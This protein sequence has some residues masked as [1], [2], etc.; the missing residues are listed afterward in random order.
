MATVC[1][2]RDAWR[3]ARHAC[4]VFARVSVCP[5]CCKG[6]F[7]SFGVEASLTNTKAVPTTPTTTH[8]L[9]QR[10]AALCDIHVCLCVCVCECL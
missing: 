7:V 8:N 5:S 6:C 2:V 9:M 1:A 10:K 3:V 4:G